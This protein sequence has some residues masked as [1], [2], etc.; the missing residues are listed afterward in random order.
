MLRR[1]R[2]KSRKPSIRYRVVTPSRIAAARITRPVR[3]SANTKLNASNVGVNVP[4]VLRPIRLRKTQVTR[5]PSG[6]SRI[7]ES[8]RCISSGRRFRSKMSPEPPVRCRAAERRFRQLDEGILGFQ[9]VCP[10]GRHHPLVAAAGGHE[11]VG[12]LALVAVDRI[13]G[14]PAVAGPHLDPRAG[15]GPG[16]RF[17]HEAG[18]GPRRDLGGAAQGDHGPGTADRRSAVFG[19]HRGRV[20]RCVFVADGQLATAIVKHPLRQPSSFGRFSRR[21]ASVRETDV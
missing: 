17:D 10:G 8:T 12:H 19:E 13:V 16:T 5:A 18:H 21:S 4:D 20:V 15:T 3:Q 11:I 9:V 14:N 1:G 2:I 7:K 6:I